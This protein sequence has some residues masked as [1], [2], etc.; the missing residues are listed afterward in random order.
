MTLR[1][2]TWYG[3]TLESD[4]QVNSLDCAASV[5][6]GIATV[7]EIVE[8]NSFATENDDDPL[9]APAQAGSLLRLAIASAH[10]LADDCMRTLDHHRKK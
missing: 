9:L 2:F 6:F 4:A 5:A 3:P 7:L 10:L 1:A 8:Q